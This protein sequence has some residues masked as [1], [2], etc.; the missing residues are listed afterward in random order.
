MEKD[1]DGAVAA[2]LNQIPASMEVT[3]DVL[4]VIVGAVV[5]ARQQGRPPA[6]NALAL[7]MH[8]VVALENR[9]EKLEGRPGFDHVETLGRLLSEFGLKD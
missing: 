4:G 5:T 2:I 7:F 8:A 9:L 1:V 6:V 3:R